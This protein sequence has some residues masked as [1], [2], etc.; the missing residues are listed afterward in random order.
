[1]VSGQLTIRPQ[2]G[3]ELHTCLN[4]CIGLISSIENL[5]IWKQKPTFQDLP[6]CKSW[7]NS[8]H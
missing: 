1:L 4:E 2:L 3:F 5:W 6:Q 8:V 7:P